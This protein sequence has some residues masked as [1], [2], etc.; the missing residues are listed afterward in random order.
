[1]KKI[2]KLLRTC[3]V[4]VLV[5]FSI[6]SGITVSATN[7]KSDRKAISSITVDGKKAIWDGEFHLYVAESNSDTAKVK[8]KLKKGWKLKKITHY[9]ENTGKSCKVK[10]GGTIK[11][12]DPSDDDDYTVLQIKA[13]KNKKS[14]TIKVAVWWLD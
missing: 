13:I 8:V 11:P 2:N 1:M 10:N 3:L 7:N 9:S 5:F 4:L 6:S 12:L 14:A